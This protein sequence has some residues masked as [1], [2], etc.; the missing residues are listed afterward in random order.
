MAHFYGTIRGSRGEESRLG[1]KESGIASEVMSYGGVVS[2]RLYFDPIRCED[3]IEISVAEHKTAGGEH[4]GIVLSCSLHDL[5]G[6]MKAIKKAQVAHRTKLIELSELCAR[7]LTDDGI[8][9]D[10]G[11]V[12][13]LDLV[14]NDAEMA[15]AKVTGGLVDERA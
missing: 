12:A 11:L 7:Q 6:Q 5:V 4:L 9:V 15:R 13:L 3:R 14:L 2:S 8:G 1:S 10:P